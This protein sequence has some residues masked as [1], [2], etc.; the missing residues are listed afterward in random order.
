MCLF[1]HFAFLLC[2]IHTHKHTF[3]VS[4]SVNWI[5]CTSLAFISFW[6]K[7]Q[8]AFQLGWVFPLTCKCWLSYHES[9][10]FVFVILVCF[11][12]CCCNVLSELEPKTKN[13][14]TNKR[15]PI[16]CSFIY[17][18]HSNNTHKTKIMRICEWRAYAISR[19]W[20]K[21]MNNHGWSCVLS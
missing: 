2:I 12:I 1:V 4:T 5:A 17:N 8:I 9:S 3:S 21:V 6:F 11:G 19:R 20:I 15:K 16:A 18:I 7:G 13:S 14:S 10:V